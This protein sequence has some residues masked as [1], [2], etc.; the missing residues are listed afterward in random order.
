MSCG[1]S[2]R[3]CARRG[4]P[5]RGG[6]RPRVDDRAGLTGILVVLKS[7]LPRG[8]LPR[9]M[10]GGSGMT[11]RRRLKAWQEAGVWEELHRVLLDRLGRAG[12]ID[13][14]RAAVDGA[15]MPEKKIL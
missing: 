7:G 9:E 12:A 15:T 11:R 6:G 3:S 10:G 1:R 13:W 8:M 2:W 5:S 14:S 4:R